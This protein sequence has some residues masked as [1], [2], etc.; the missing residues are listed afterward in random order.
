MKIRRIVICMVALTFFTCGLV[1]CSKSTEDN[2]NS[3]SNNKDVETMNV[4]EL[5]TTKDNSHNESNTK[6]LLEN[7][8]T[9]EIE[10]VNG[11]NLDGI[12]LIANNPVTYKFQNGSVH[13]PSVVY[14]DGTY[15]VFG[16]HLA[17]AKSTDLMNWTMIG[18]GVNTTN[19]IIN[20]PR[21]EMKEAF[22]WAKTTTF[23]APDV[24]KL[25]D[26]RY[27]M[28]YCTCEGSSPLASLGLA[29]SDK[30][31]GP[32]NDLGIFLRSGMGSN[33]KSEDGNTYNANVHPNV[34]DPSLYYD[35]EGRLWMMYGSYS[36][37]FYVLEMDVN[38][39]FPLTSGYGKKILGG[40]HVRIEAPYVMYSP[41][42]DYYYMFMTFGGLDSV[43]GYNMRVARS[44]NPDGPYFDSNGVDMIECKGPAGTFFND[45]SI[46][47]YGVKLM[48]NYR[49]AWLEGE[50]SKIRSG[51]VSPGHNS[52]YYDKESG[53]YYL[54][55]HSR[56]E[57]KGEGHEIRVHEMFMNDDGWPIVSPY[58]YID[59]VDLNVGKVYGKEEL[60]GVYKYVNHGRKITKDVVL[61][62]LIQLN[63]DNT[64]SG[65][66]EGTWSVLSN[67]NI[68]LVID[69]VIYKGIV[70]AKW[71]EYGKKNVMTFTALSDSG[72]AIW[73]SGVKPIE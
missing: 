68:E 32:Y 62:E 23:W 57:G 8:D 20:N 73:G 35:K 37:G 5:D 60:L 45:A 12:K 16:S 53:N 50:Q 11:I 7:T 13:D 25:S 9:N 31:E 72:I 40:N 29:V 51:Y 30:V 2:V 33:M 19:P 41:D 42:T 22:E 54:I 4:N 69:N 38:T 59:G 1:A 52:A 39:G 3:E 55:F 46:E 65:Y 64:I 34:I 43:G 70:S 10:L 58:R 17:G 27:Y 24:I 14:E 67:N 26:G 36:G 21:E 61:S 71:D 15:Y 28:Y 66:V 44:K 18:S 47:K 48:G 6:E 56:F 63:D 49:F